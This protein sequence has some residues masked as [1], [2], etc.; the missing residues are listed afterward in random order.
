MCGLGV[1]DKKFHLATG[2]VNPYRLG[3]LSMS[4]SKVSY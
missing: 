2:P 1:C 4:F 3:E